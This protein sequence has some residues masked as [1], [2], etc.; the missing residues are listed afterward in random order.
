[1]QSGNR[2]ARLVLALAGSIAETMGIP[3]TVFITFV[4]IVLAFTHHKI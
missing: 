1:M 4:T 3:G 2:T